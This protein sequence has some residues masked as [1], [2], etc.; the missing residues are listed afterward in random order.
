MAK[1][2]LTKA[3]TLLGEVQDKLSEVK[4]LLSDY[5]VGIPEV[6]VTVPLGIR[7]LANEFKS[8]LKCSPKNE[9]LDYFDAYFDTRGVRFVCYCIPERERAFYEEVE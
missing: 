1:R 9:L 8:P 5:E 7:E 6:V 4:G 2:K 3:V